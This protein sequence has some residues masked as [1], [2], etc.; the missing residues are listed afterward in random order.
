MNCAAVDR[1]LSEGVPVAEL[2][3]RPD[4]Q[5]HLAGCA[6]CRQLFDWLEQ[7]APAPELPSLEPRLRLL[8]RADLRPVQPMPSLGRA[9]AS[10]L[11]LA[12]GLV[13]LHAM[14]MGLYGWE[15]L[16]TAQMGTFAA[17]TGFAL[18]T[19]VYCLVSSLQPGT[20]RRI[21]PALPLLLLTAG[22]P[23]WTLWWFP[24]QWHQHFLRDGLPCL[25]A[26]LLVAGFTGAITFTLARRGYSTNWP[27]TGAL[28]G[29]FGGA[30]AAIALQLSCPDHEVA[31]IL[32]W[33]GLTLVISVLGGYWAGRHVQAI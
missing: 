8:L 27:L 14:A 26:G 13:A 10:A 33:H 18:I 3:Q 25:A 15:K 9:I 5:T 22:L 24:F 16:N 30:V 19:S 6:R 29:L 11:V 4:V 23:A 31:H 32:V 2:R 17:L 1:L 20:P 21:H 28:I 7:P 12:A